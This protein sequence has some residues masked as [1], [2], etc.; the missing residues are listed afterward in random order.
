LNASVIDLGFIRR[1]DDVTNYVNNGGE[2]NFSGIDIDEFILNGVDS[3]GDNSFDRVIDSLSEAFELN[4]ETANYTSSLTSRVYV[5]ATYQ[6]TEK[7]MAGALLQTEFFKNKI[8]P[9]ITL[10]YNHRFNKLLNLTASYTIINNSYNNLGG[11]LIFQPGPIQF[12][13]MADNILG[14]FQPQNARHLQL[15]TGINLIIGKKNEVG[16]I[17]AKKENNEE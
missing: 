15:R 17:K 14:T 16:D 9:S 11:G 7:G 4:E 12:Y 1:K 3:S 10:S 13:V 5:G 2:F 6:I 8:N